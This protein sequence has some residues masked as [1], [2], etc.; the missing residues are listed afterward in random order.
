MPWRN[1]IGSWLLIT[2]VTGLIWIWASGE[3]REEKSI[4]T[5]A[6]FTVQQGDNAWIIEPKIHAFS[7]VVEGSRL[8][9]QNVEALAKNG[10]FFQLQPNMDDPQVDIEEAVRSNQDFQRTGATLVSVD[11]PTASPKIDERI[12][13]QLNVAPNLPGVQTV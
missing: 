7:M 4:M 11:R 3:T 5:K 9:I 1:E 13:L 6:T 8:S 2:V 12:A 10:F